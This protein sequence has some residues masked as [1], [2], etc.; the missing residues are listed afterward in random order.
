MDGSS[1]LKGQGMDVDIVLLWLEGEMGHN[2][3]ISTSIS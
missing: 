1:S 3:R 2:L